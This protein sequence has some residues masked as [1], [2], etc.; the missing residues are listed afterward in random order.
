MPAFITALLLMFAAAHATAAGLAT[1]LSG[2]PI[3]R[4]APAGSRAVVLF[5]AASDCPISNRYVPEIQKLATEFAPDG[6]Y[7][8][9]VYPNPGDNAKVVR[10]HNAEY[11]ITTRTALDTNQ[12]LVKMAHAGVTPE[13]AV[14]VPNGDQWREV[15]R[16]R[17]DDRYINLGTQRPAPTHHDLE[18]AIR[19]V[20]KNQPVPQSGGPAVG[21]TIIP[22]NP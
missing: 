5:F 12:T 4:L 7:I 8:W 2:Q 21:C 6:V 20:L 10:A 19:A 14:L 1:D 3:A 17:I 15:Y 11:A 22:L 9:F 18:D 16:G 13:A